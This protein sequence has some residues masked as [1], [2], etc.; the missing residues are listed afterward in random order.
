M[1]HVTCAIGD[2]V[3]DSP[4]VKFAD[5]GV[6]M[7]S[8]ADATKEAADI[9]FVDNDINHIVFGIEEG[10]KI[11]DNLKKSICYVMTSQMSEWLPFVVLLVFRIPIPVFTLLIDGTADFVPAISYAF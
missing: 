4:I 6:S 8:G 11:F 10:R 3:N 2:G 5:A 9:V 7:G 1:G